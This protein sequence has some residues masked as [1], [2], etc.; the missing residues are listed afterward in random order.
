MYLLRV[1]D[2]DA[3]AAV[4]DFFRRAHVVVHEQRGGLLRVSIPGAPSSLHEW[5]EVSGYVATWNAL[6]PA[7]PVEVID[8]AD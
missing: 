6:H 2:L 5:R 3:V 8:A 4:C 1:S 7:T